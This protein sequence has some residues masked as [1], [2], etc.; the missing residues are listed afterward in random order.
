MRYRKYAKMTRK[1]NDGTEYTETEFVYVE[2]DV[3]EFMMTMHTS[4]EL[5]L[6]HRRAHLWFVRQRTLALEKLKSAISLSALAAQ[7]GLTDKQAMQALLSC[8]HVQYRTFTDHDVIYFTDFAAKVHHH[9]RRSPPAPPAPPPPVV[10][11]PVG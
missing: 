2:E 11:P 4:L 7:L 6:E 8:E 10:P 9:P 3:H 5:Y 1:R